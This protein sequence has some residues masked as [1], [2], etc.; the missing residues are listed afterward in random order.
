M[1]ELP[2]TESILNIVLKHA[3]KNRVSRVVSITLHIGELSDLEDRWLQHYFDYLSRQTLAGG[4]KLRIERLPIVLKCR[5]CDQTMHI[6]RKDLGA[7][8]CPN[9]AGIGDFSLV[10]G[11]QYYIKDMEAV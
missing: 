2:V 6:T 9:C 4:A 10:S 5:N 3:E 7:I 1:H 8:E 11:R